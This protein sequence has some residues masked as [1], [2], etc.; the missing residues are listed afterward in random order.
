MT[1]DKS[2]WVYHYHFGRQSPRKVPPVRDPRHEDFAA[3]YAWFRDAER[4]RSFTDGGFD[5]LNRDLGIAWAAYTYTDLEIEYLRL[6]GGAISKQVVSRRTEL[7]DVSGGPAEWEGSWDAAVK[8]AAT[9][10]PAE[11]LEMPDRFIVHLAMAGDVA[12]E[13][14]EAYPKERLEPVA[15]EIIAADE[16]PMTVCE[17]VPTDRVL[18]AIMDRL[19][20]GRSQKGW[21]TGGRRRWSNGPNDLLKIGPPLYDRIATSKPVEGAQAYL[22]LEALGRSNRPEAVTRLLH[23]SKENQYQISSRAKELLA[24]RGRQTIEVGLELLTGSRQEQR[25][26]GLI[27]LDGRDLN[28]EDVEAL[29]KAR[30]VER[31]TKV[32]ERLDEML[33]PYTQLSQADRDWNRVHDLLRSWEYEQARKTGELLNGLMKLEDRV[34]RLVGELGAA[35]SDVRLRA[36]EVLRELGDERAVPLLREARTNQSVAAVADMVAA[37]I[38]ALSNVPEASDE[39]LDALLG[40]LGLSAPS[41]LKHVPALRWSGGEELSSASVGALLRL[42]E[43]LLPCPWGHELRARLDPDYASAALVELREQFDRDNVVLRHGWVHRATAI[44]GSSVDVA[45]LGRGLNELVKNNFHKQA[46]ATIDVL[47]AEGSP[48]AL[49]RLEHWSRKARTAH[50]R[51]YCGRALEQVAASRGWSADELVERVF[52]SF[53]FDENGVR[54]VAFGV[55]GDLTLRLSGTDFEMVDESGKAWSRY[56]GELAGDGAVYD[57]AKRTLIELRREMRASARMIAQRLEDSM[58]ARRTWSWNSFLEVF[59]TN[60]FLFHFAQGLV[61]SVDGTPVLVTEEHELATVDGDAVVPDSETAIRLM[62]PLEV[63]DDNRHRWEML[64]ADYE[65]HSPFDQLDR[66]F[67]AQPPFT[68]V[69]IPAERVARVAKERGLLPRDRTI[70]GTYT[71]EFGGRTITLRAMPEVRPPGFDADQDVELEVPE[72]ADEILV[73]E[74]GR[75]WTGMMG[76]G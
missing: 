34:E 72:G 3:K 18:D 44:L 1:D 67:G 58:V 70:L 4:V 51:E 55:R 45:R 47:A 7:G 37:T 21:R 74:L 61:W 60:P 24:Y 50:F 28:S 12:R 2:D 75:L 43:L 52:P 68:A 76:D 33:R 35:D 17:L 27:L 14:L 31:A 53:G 56:P 6:R 26:D 38:F 30:K 64:L 63:D 10:S 59:M 11:L 20:A 25:L 22:W 32:K 23:Y 71:R 62:H 13:F 66:E 65:R 8:H 46:K 73:A 15:L 16:G 41:D 48:E 40:G 36:L 5:G 39:E 42:V 49:A 19:R 29:R 54:T 57:E 69:M 9:L